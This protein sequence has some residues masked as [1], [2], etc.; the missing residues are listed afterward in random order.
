MKL[1]RVFIDVYCEQIHQSHSKCVSHGCPRAPV[2]CT[3]H[4]MS[5]I[6]TIVLLAIQAIQDLENQYGLQAAS[7]TRQTSWNEW[8]AHD[9]FLLKRGRTRM[10]Y[11]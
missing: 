1:L 3:T 7:E 2:P 6:H 5:E 9:R 10:T 11:S 4:K 8:N